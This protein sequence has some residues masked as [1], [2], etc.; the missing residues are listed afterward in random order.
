MLSDNTM[1]EHRSSTCINSDNALIMLIW[2]NMMHMY[3]RLL[4]TAHSMVTKVKQHTFKNHFGYLLL[5]KKKKYF[6]S[7]AL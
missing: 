7:L 2:L 4:K 1:I 6:I 5:V 3:P